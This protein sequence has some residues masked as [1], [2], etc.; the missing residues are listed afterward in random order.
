MS[1]DALLLAHGA[2]S[3]AE[4]LRAAGIST[5]DAFSRANLRELGLTIG[6]RMKLKPAQQALAQQQWATP[7]LPSSVVLAAASTT[8]ATIAVQQGASIQERHQCISAERWPSSRLSIADAVSALAYNETRA[9]APP[10]AAPC[11]Q[12]AGEALLALCRGLQGHRYAFSVAEYAEAYAQAGGAGEDDAPL[13]MLPPPIL[14]DAV[15]LR[16]LPS[17]HA[18]TVGGHFDL[19]RHN[20]SVTQRIR[21]RTAR[22]LLCRCLS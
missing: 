12:T 5:R 14:A 4:S 22:A 15:T 11:G 9:N 21:L 10:A 8:T 19:D 18:V 13:P 7:S 2:T 1:L 3:E 6:A 17:A 20:A 16:P